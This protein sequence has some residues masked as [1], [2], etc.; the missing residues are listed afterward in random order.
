MGKRNSIIKTDAIDTDLRLD[1]LELITILKNR[2]SVFLPNILKVYESVKELLNTRIPK[3]FANYT[4]HNTGHSFRIMQYMAKLVSDPNLLDDL[5]ITI[6]IYSALLH[7]VGMAVSEDRIK[8]IKKDKFQYSN[9]K[10]SS[11]KKI[12]NADENLVLEE[13]VRKAHATFSASYI[14][15]NHHEEFSIPKLPTLSFAKELALICESHTHDFDFIKRNLSNYEVRGDYHFNCQFIASILRLADILDIDSN[16]TPYNLYKMINPI[17]IGDSEWKQ[18]FIISNNDKIYYNEKTQQKRIVFYGKSTNASIHRKLLTYISWVEN[19][20]ANTCNLVANMLPQ[21]KMV[22]ELKPEINIQAEGYSFSDYKMTLEFKAISALLMG[23]KIYGNKS[24]GLR[25]LVQNS[26][27]ACKIRQENEKELHEFGQEEYKPKIKVIFNSEKNQILIKDN[28]M[29]MS[30]DIIK[31]H[32]LNIGVSY[33]ASADFQLNDYQYHPIGNF[34]IGFLSCFMLS[35][36]VTVVTRHFNSKYKYVIELEKNSEYTSLTEI[37]DVSFDGT[38]VILNYSTFMEI[39]ENKP[40]QV[41]DFLSTYFLTDGIEFEII[42]K[43]K[44]TKYSISNPLNQKEKKEAGIIRIELTQ[45]LNEMEGYA[46]LK[47]KTHFVRNF[48]DLNFE[49]ELYTYDR[50]SK[51]IKVEDK[52]ALK[53]DDYLVDQEIKYIAIPLVTYDEEDDYLSGLKFTENDVDEVVRKM[54]RDL[55]WI[56]I[57]VEKKYYDEID[58]KRLFE[59]DGIF[60]YLFYEDLVALGHQKDCPTKC[61]IKSVRLFEGE[62][63]KLYM[64]FDKISQR[65]SYLSYLLPLFR[66][67]TGDLFVRSVGIKDFRFSLGFISSIFEVVK[68]RLNVNSKKLI[69]DISRNNLDVQ[70]AELLNYVVTKSIHIGACEIL[71]IELQEKDT[72]KKFIKSYYQK[73]TEFEV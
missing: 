52:A 37:E 29:G 36:S 6:L 18:H 25:E 8:E 59:M 73:T 5:E 51:L 26:I 65:H 61:F 17:G 13:Y 20:L 72:L 35:D 38:E 22:Y 56:S 41:K 57:L 21:Y 40:E 19:E 49:G 64:P 69:P 58:E 24:L 45:Y 66:R 50:E 23:E 54:D 34:G 48:E 7:D 2:K 63:N 30:I 44:K 33:Y 71:K 70:S 14:V 47:P 3:V 9:I 27:D 42:D 32:F 68:I 28:G 67:S 60:D 11:M 10:F 1:N 55:Q 53:I 12:M 62:K 16:R 15:E 43:N 39:F 31:N 4:L 46:L